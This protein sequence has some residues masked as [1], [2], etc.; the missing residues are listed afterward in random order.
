MMK[1]FIQLL[2]T[3]AVCIAVT[4]CGDSH[5]KVMTDQIEWM[6]DIAVVVEQ[7]AEGE[8]SSAEG[9]ERVREL[10]QEAH[11]FMER[12]KALDND[13]TPHKAKRLVEKYSRPTTEA[14]GGVM[15]AMQ[16]SM[17]N[18]TMERDLQDAIMELNLQ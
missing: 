3:F 1:Y 11:T 16:K 6:D 10:G 15:H 17:K 13:L 12:K 9:A 7:V 8:L 18:G 4:G 2:A 5:D 14:Y